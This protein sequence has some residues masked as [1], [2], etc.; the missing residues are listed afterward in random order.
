M[1]KITRTDYPPTPRP[2]RR[3]DQP[4]AVSARPVPPSS[5]GQDTAI[6]ARIEKHAA[7]AAK[8]ARK[9]ERHVAGIRLMMLLVVALAALA[10]VGGALG[11]GM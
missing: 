10:A 7:E 9:A 6:L 11:G 5:S 8:A 1:A 4:G 2:T 3:D